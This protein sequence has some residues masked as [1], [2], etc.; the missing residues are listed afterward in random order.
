MTVYGEDAQLARSEDTELMPDD[1]AESADNHKAQDERDRRLLA[2]IAAARAATDPLAS[3]RETVAMGELLSPYWA[4][5]KRTVMWRL[6]SARIDEADAEDIT[7]RVMEQMVTKLKETTEFDM[8]FRVLV[9]LN[10]HSRAVDWWRSR[11]VRTRNI[12][13]HGGELPDVPASEETVLVHAEVMAE[14]IEDLGPCDRQI[15]VE[16]Y[17][18]GVKPDHIAEGLGVTREVVDTAQCRALAKLRKDPR[19]HAVRNRLRETA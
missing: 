15:L 2:R 18:A 10:A 17:V 5:T 9:F 13:D 16:R 3:M 19:I 8:P 6:A 1:P 14:I 7:S 4:K 12:E 11:R